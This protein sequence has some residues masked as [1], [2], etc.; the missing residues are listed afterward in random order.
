[1]PVAGKKGE[2]SEASRK[3]SGNKGKR[4]KA[5]SGQ[6]KAGV[7]YPTGRLNRLLKEG[8]YSERFSRSAGIFLAGVLEYITAEIIELA[9]SVCEEN[10]KKTIAPKHLNLA[11]RSDP[12]LNKLMHSI[13]IS[14]GGQLPNIQEF[15]QP[16]KKVGKSGNG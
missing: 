16:N 15:L 6:V 14:Q 12:E 5:V 7:L 9:G 1:M 4:A 3:K 11:V 10:K 8:R 2:K 13:T